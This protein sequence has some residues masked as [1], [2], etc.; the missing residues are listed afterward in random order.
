MSFQ[1]SSNMFA[2]CSTG[3][4]I[5]VFSLCEKFGVCMLWTA[6]FMSCLFIHVLVVT[7]QGP[8]KHRQTCLHNAQLVWNVHVFM[9]GSLVWNKRF[10]SCYWFLFLKVFP[11]I[12]KHVCTMLNWF[13]NL[14][15]QVTRSLLCLDHW[16]GVNCCMSCLFINVLV[17]GF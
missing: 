16:F 9:L 12:V 13:R 4:E 2:H 7:S 1:T 8:S 3:L 17:F 10:I 11:N 5:F 6:W 14:C 15:F